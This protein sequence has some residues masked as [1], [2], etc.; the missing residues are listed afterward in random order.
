MI[1]IGHKLDMNEECYAIVK[2]SPLLW[3][4]LNKYEVEE[5]RIDYNLFRPT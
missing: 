5:I 4:P 1:V 2:K 3:V